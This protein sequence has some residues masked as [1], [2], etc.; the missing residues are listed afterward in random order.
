MNVTYLIGNGFDLHLGMKTSFP[1]IC[2]AYVQEK[3]NDKIISDFKDVLK[4]DA[5]KYKNWADFE[6]AMGEYS[7]NYDDFNEY[8]LCIHSFRD[9]MINY[10]QNEEKSFFDALK[11]YDVYDYAYSHFLKNLCDSIYLSHKNAVVEDLKA[12]G[13]IEKKFISFNYTTVLDEFV[14]KNNHNRT[15]VHDYP[16]VIHIHNDLNGSVL[17]GVDN[18]E[19]ILNVSFRGDRRK[20]RT[21]IKPFINNELEYNKVRKTKR[22]IA[23]SDVI[24]V[25]GMSFGDSDLTWKKEVLKWLKS[26]ISN[27]LVFFYYNDYSFKKYDSDDIL[28]LE[29]DFKEEVL[30]KMGCSENIEQLMEQIIIPVN[31]DLMDFDKYIKDTF[32]K[33]VNVNNKLKTSL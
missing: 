18:E 8:K 14:S 9:F 23:E 5:P 11:E 4:K 17:F 27:L 22:I 21:F 13:D 2:A 33:R 24:C 7:T 12:R 3:T 16:D 30:E 26:D 20:N 1:S 31:E 28:N 15:A 10:L 25:Y 29:D 32:Q 6:I 19:Q